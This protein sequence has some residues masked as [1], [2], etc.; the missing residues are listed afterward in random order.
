[1]KI[2]CP[3]CGQVIEIEGI[4]LPQSRTLMVNIN[5]LLDEA[6]IEYDSRKQA[7]KNHFRQ[8]NSTISYVFPKTDCLN[9]SCRYAGC[10]ICFTGF[11]ETEKQELA[12]IQ[13]KLGIIAKNSISRKVQFLIC[14]P[15]AG[16]S[17]IEKC[18]ELNIPIVS[19]EDFLKQIVSESE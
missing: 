10:A 17:K 3:H 14:G 13:D 8:A 11:S 19:A 16:P 1:M 12:K 2:V 6:D 9:P 4:S 7:V 15:N 5:A 18:K